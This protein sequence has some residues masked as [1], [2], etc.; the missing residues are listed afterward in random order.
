MSVGEASYYNYPDLEVHMM[1]QDTQSLIIPEVLKLKQGSSL[2]FNSGR[3]VACT[4]SQG[5]VTLDDVR[6]EP[7]ETSVTLPDG[8]LY[9]ISEA[10]RRLGPDDEE[11]YNI[12]IKSLEADALQLARA[13][14][15]NINN[16][17]NEN[18]K[19]IME[20]FVASVSSL[21]ER[22][23]KLL[24]DVHDFFARKP[25]FVETIA[26]EN[27]TFDTVGKKIDGL[28][29]HGSL[30]KAAT[31]APG[32]ATQ[33][34]GVEERRKLYTMMKR[35]RQLTVAPPAEEKDPSENPEEARLVAVQAV[36][37]LCLGG[38][39]IMRVGGKLSREIGATPC[40]SYIESTCPL[41]CCHSFFL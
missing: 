31:A 39:Q 4:I 7:G 6:V 33:G 8:V 37:D 29:R 17:D 40:Y 1:V 22:K 27:E 13:I 18:F 19:S 20:S 28:L 32:F 30:P 38:I 34:L 2:V 14:N 5:F 15:S 41:M 16:P 23:I 25:S 10:T 3:T 21:K 26:E 11:Y 24:A 12:L 9:H 36:L 35:L